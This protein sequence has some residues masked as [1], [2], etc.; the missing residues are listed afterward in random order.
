[1]TWNYPCGW[2]ALGEAVSGYGP[3]VGGGGAGV[4]GHVEEG[5]AGDYQGAVTSAAALGARTATRTDDN[6]AL[7]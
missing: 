4:I 2:T 5:R 7:G 1:M 3:E 6:K